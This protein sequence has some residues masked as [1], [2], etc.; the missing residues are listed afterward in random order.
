MESPVTL[1]MVSEQKPTATLRVMGHVFSVRSLT[2]KAQFHTQA[3]LCDTA[4]DKVKVKKKLP[5]PGTS[6]FPS[7]YHIT[8]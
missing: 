1:I 5:F 8:S 7:Q 3:N 6:I 4:V 2:T